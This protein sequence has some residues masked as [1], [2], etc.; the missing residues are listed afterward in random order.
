[1]PR[2]W[3]YSNEERWYASNSVLQLTDLAQDPVRELQRTCGGGVRL[4]GLGETAPN[5]DVLVDVVDEDLSIRSVPAQRDRRV[6]LERPA[7]DLA[8]GVFDVH[9]EVG[10][11]V[12]PVELPED[13]REV[14]ALRAVPFSGER[15]MRQRRCCRRP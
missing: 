1:M 11:R 13:T 5:P 14:P 8:A 4:A 12:L 10:V 15:M 3:R 2:G 6:R 9:E 7:L